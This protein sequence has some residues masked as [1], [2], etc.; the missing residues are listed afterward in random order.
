VD[1]ADSTGV[2]L[3][4]TWT[5][6]S[7]TPGFQGAD[8]LHDG[9]VKNGTCS[10]RF[11]P[12]L[13][14]GG[15][16]EVFL[17]WTAHANRA[18][19]VPVEIRLPGGLVQNMTVNQQ[20][21]GSQWVSVGSFTFAAGFSPTEGSVTIRNSGVNGYV[22]ADAVRFL[23]GVDVPTIDLWATDARAAE[24]HAGFAKPATVSIRRSGPLGNPVTVRYTSGGAALA[25][26]DFVPLTGSL[27][28]PAG[29]ASAT[30]QVVPLADALAEGS[31][32]LTL[33]LEV[34]PAYRLAE[35][36]A[37]T[38]AI[39]DTPFDQWRHSRFSPGQLADPAVSGPEADPDKDGTNNLLEFFSGGDPLTAGMPPRLKLYPAPVCALEVERDP[40][41]GELFLRIEESMDLGGW[42]PVLAP[43]EVSGGDPLELLRFSLGQL[44]ESAGF[45]RVA[46]SQTPFSP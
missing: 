21:N 24:P 20:V 5:A 46:V 19:N 23:N 15:T 13:P 31:E 26:Q 30:L 22:I 18:S 42:E 43:V 25:G 33:S 29:V 28:L 2:S 4:G 36:V 27:V 14:D 34:D 44:S 11:T 32:D 35:L 7:A 1:N 16:Y 10:A 9:G 12:D 17:R 3:T 39:H 45:F 41:A 40:L 37:E 6:S 38:L 8:Y